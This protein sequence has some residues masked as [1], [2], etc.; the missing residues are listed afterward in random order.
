MIKETLKAKK[1]IGRPTMYCDE[2]IDEI[3]AR[4][5]AGESLNRILKSRSEM[6]AFIT[7]YQWLRK[8]PDFTKKYDDAR[9]HQADTLADEII[10][11]ADEAPRQIIDDKGIARTDSGY[12]S[13][14]RNRVDARKWVASKLKPDKWG[15]RM[16]I[17]GVKGGHPIEFNEKESEDSLEKMMAIIDNIEMQKRAG[18]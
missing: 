13:W 9:L 15:D 8:Y 11:I 10:A 7:I 14:T 16:A 1:A 12:V 4:L 5:S 17:G 6:P 2:L 18:G 3:C